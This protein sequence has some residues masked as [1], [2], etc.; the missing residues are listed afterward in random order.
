LTEN[1]LD[2]PKKFCQAD[3]RWSIRETRRA[4]TSARRVGKSG[5]ET[6]AMGNCAEVETEPGMPKQGMAL[7]QQ[8]KQISLQ[9]Q[10]FRFSLT[11]EIQK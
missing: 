6:Q 10:E 9:S 2:F 11:I 8:Y 3:L 7:R 1:L 4:A 5:L